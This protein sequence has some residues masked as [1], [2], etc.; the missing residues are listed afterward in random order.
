MKAER[1][2]TLREEFRATRRAASAPA[3][4][5]RRLRQDLE[6][7]VPP[8]AAKKAEKDRQRA[9]EH[10]RATSKARVTDW[11]TFERTREEDAYEA[12]DKW[13]LEDRGDCQE[14]LESGIWSPRSTVEVASVQRRSA[15]SFNKSA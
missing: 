5:S 12:T 2:K 14:S 4:E 10:R 3:V 6:A 8:R 1:S 15:G 7:G 11:T 9:A 13:D